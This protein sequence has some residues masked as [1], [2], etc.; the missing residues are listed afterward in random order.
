MTWA[1]L[2]L[3]TFVVAL[4][5]FTL[6]AALVAVKGLGELRQLLAGLEGGSSRPEP[7]EDDADT[8]SPD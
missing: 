3:V 1:L 5:G 8:S 7:G 4:G 2:W 6:V